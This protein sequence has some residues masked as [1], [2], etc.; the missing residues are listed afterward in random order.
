[1]RNEMSLIEA[2]RGCR[3][4]T[5]AVS[6]SFL[7][8]VTF[9]SHESLA[10]PPTAVKELHASKHAPIGFNKSKVCLPQDQIPVQGLSLTEKETSLLGSLCWRPDLET[11]PLHEVA[12]NSRGVPSGVECDVTNW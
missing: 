9:L 1:M 8:S 10:K 2:R 7:F 6:L 3:T 11:L 5:V 12:A 4:L